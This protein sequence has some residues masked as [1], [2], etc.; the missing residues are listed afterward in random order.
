[1]VNLDHNI[2][3]DPFIAIDGQQIFLHSINARMLEREY[4]CLKNGPTLITGT[5]VE[6]ESG[7]MAEELRKRLRYLQHLPLTCQ[8]LVIEVDLPPQIVSQE[9]KNYFKG[10]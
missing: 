4:G 7:S 2:N 8:F 1:M 5:I 3:L 6:I 9:T 10:N